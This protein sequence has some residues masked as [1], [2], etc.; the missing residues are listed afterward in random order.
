MFEQRR[1]INRD[2]ISQARKE[3]HTY[4]R[5]KHVRARSQRPAC[6]CT[7]VGTFSRLPKICKF[8]VVSSVK[9]RFA[10]GVMLRTIREKRILRLRETRFSN[11]SSS[12]IALAQK[13]I[14]FIKSCFLR[15]FGTLDRRAVESRFALGESRKTSFLPKQPSILIARLDTSARA[16]FVNRIRRRKRAVRIASGKERD[17]RERESAERREGGGGR[18]SE[19][20]IRK[21]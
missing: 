6:T 4:S 12:C 5:R 7:S 21:G 20:A 2:R 8:T 13:I 16:L 3:F 18:G 19:R 9:T 1:I 11:S 17:A 15:H 10:T 14:I